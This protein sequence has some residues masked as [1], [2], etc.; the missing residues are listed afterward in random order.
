MKEKSLPLVPAGE[1]GLTKL[2]P[3]KSGLFA[4]SRIDSLV[5]SRDSSS[6]NTEAATDLHSKFEKGA[7]RLG[8]EIRMLEQQRQHLRSIEQQR[9]IIYR[10]LTAAMEVLLHSDNTLNTALSQLEPSAELTQFFDR[11]RD[12]IDALENVSASLVTNFEC[13]C[14]AWEQ[15]A[16]TCGRAKELKAEMAAA[17]P[18]VDA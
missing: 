4:F 11:N 3:P 13:W 1:V 10:E 18:L 9:G 16:Q 15:Y 8:T 17:E 2:D 12:A 6:A 14:L 5:E 7:R